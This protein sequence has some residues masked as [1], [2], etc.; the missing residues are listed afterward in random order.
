MCE[1]E[2]VLLYLAAFAGTD[3]VV[4]AGG[5]VLADEAGFV[6]SRWRRRRRRTGDNFL[7]ARALRLHG[8][9]LKEGKEEGGR[10]KKKKTKDK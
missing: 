4:V 5:F 2:C 1:R 9:M 8:W 3:A 6:D 7:R 10:E